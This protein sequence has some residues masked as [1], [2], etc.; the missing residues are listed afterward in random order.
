MKIISFDET[1]REL[2]NALE[3]ATK[4]VTALKQQFK[5]LEEKFDRF[6]Y[7]ET[8]V[9]DNGVIDKEYHI[10]KDIVIDENGRWKK[11]T[12]IWC[13]WC[14]HPF[15]T[16]PIGLPE[17]YCRESKKFVV[18]DC[19]CSFNCAHAFNVSLDDHKVWERYALLTRLKNVIFANT[20]LENKRIVCAPPRKMLKAFGGSKTIDDFRG[21]RISVPKKYINLLPPSV[22]FFATIEEI[23]IYFETS[24]TNSIYEKLRSRSVNPSS[25]KTK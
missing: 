8:V 6:K 18:R 19:F 10:T 24:K 16:I 21:T 11:Q 12:P 5:D 4:E 15:T 25:L 9:S 20:D 3:K 14:C 7:L 23:P 13:N 1:D 22:P 2:E 17:F